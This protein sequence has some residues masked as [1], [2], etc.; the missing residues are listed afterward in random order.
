MS[1]IDKDTVPSGTDAT[2]LQNLEDANYIVEI[3]QLNESKTSTEL[4]NNIISTA[5]CE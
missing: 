2:L 5:T 3:L 4:L 1:K